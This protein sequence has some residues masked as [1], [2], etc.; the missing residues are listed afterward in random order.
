MPIINRKAPTNIP[1]RNAA[2]HQIIT[3]P[4]SKKRRSGVVHRCRRY[5]ANSKALGAPIHVEQQ[6][7]QERWTKTQ[8]V[9]SASAEPLNEIFF[10]I[11]TSGWR[12]SPTRLLRSVQSAIWDSSSGMIGSPPH[13]PLPNVRRYQRSRA[14]FRSARRTKQVSL[15]RFWSVSKR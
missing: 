1:K 10:Q 13:A 14:A 3:N 15:Y 11:E 12:P 8:S 7:H 9:A 5:L 2:M 6:S 4:P